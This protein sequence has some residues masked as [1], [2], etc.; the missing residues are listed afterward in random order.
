M[1][2]DGAPF[3]GDWPIRDAHPPKGKAKTGLAQV[4]PVLDHS[5]PLLKALVDQDTLH[6]ESSYALVKQGRIKGGKSAPGS[7]S[8][9]LG[10]GELSL[11]SL[12]HF[13][14]AGTYSLLSWRNRPSADVDDY[15]GFI[16]DNPS[17]MPGRK[18]RHITQPEF[19]LSPIV[20]QH[21]RTT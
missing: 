20:H 10:I 7:S 21:Y 5:A 18:Q 12:N 9:D 3:Q 16:A 8:K 13:A 4:H 19:I 11:D 14:A 1:F 15:D 17:V 2:H 6:G